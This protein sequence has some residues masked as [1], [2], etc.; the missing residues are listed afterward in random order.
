MTLETLTRQS[1]GS[2]LKQRGSKGS[3][4]PLKLVDSGKRTAVLNRPIETSQSKPRLTASPSHRQEPKKISNG[5]DEASCSAERKAASKG[6]PKRRTS[7]EKCNSVEK[8]VQAGDFKSMP[9]PTTQRST[10]Q[11]KGADRGKLLSLQKS[12]ERV[13]KELKASVERKRKTSSKGQVT[14]TTQDFSSSNKTND[15]IIT[16]ISN[17]GIDHTLK[18]QIERYKKMQVQ[19]RLQIQSEL[20]SALADIWKEERGQRMA[21][22]QEF[23][24]ILVRDSKKIDELVAFLHPGSTSRVLAEI[25]RLIISYN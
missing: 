16:R 12:L 6:L 2:N 20:I 13:S 3:L 22:E 7:Q 11:S 24:A 8:P 17:I 19:E 21:C 15:S 9:R 23:E 5:R 18:K 25:K 4:L 1:I 10:V 14:E